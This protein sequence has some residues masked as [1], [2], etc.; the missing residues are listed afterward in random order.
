MIRHPRD[1]TARFSC[2]WRVGA[3]DRRV[4]GSLHEM[5]G[6]SR[7]DWRS[8]RRRFGSGWSPRRRRFRERVVAAAVA[9]RRHGDNPV[10]GC[11]RE[12]ERCA[13]EK[14]PCGG[15]AS[16]RGGSAELCA[17]FRR[18]RRAPG[19]PRNVSPPGAG[20]RRTR[21]AAES[22]CHVSPGGAGYRCPR[23]FSCSSVTLAR[24]RVRGM[25][26]GARVPRSGMC[27]LVCA[28]PDGVRLQLV[29][30]EGG[31][32]GNRNQGKSQGRRKDR[33]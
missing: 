16:R 33:A 18:T 14:I 15:F 25:R 17:G 3:A 4:P 5:H 8:R 11:P 13:R 6:G 23:L 28:C 30:E 9:Y 20:Y 32:F 2:S 10:G 22:E 24:P 7:G 27:G 26:V 19:S 21:L 31:D 29:G 1:A 12:C